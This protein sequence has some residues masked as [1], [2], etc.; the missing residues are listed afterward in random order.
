MRRLAVLF[1]RRAVAAAAV[2][3]AILGWL[4][5][6][7]VP[8][9]AGGPTSVL[10]VSKATGDT[11][12]LY[13]SDEDYDQLMSA[14]GEDPAPDREAPAR[15][16]GPGGEQI[17]ITWLI[18]DVSVWRVDHVIAHAEGRPWI[19]THLPDGGKP[20]TL[21]HSSGGVW[22]RATDPKQLLGVLD[23]LGVLDEKTARKAGRAASASSD[24]PAPAGA[25]E[26]GSTTTTATGTS[27]AAR[28]I[29]QIGWWWVLPAIAAGLLAGAGGRRLAGSLFRLRTRHRGPGP[30]QQ[31]IDA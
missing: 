8:A 29:P 6:A 14:V 18:H 20:G 9:G 12:S 15:N 27:P 22:H 7:A 31:L 10:L 19:Q 13:H 30:R 16:T 28:G 23:R 4:L 26:P 24:E 21:D 11:A 5:W 17:T 3:G 2:V 1:T 25:A